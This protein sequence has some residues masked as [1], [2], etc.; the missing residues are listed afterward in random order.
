A[1]R[2]LA[3]STH[4]RID[5]YAEPVTSFLL[6]SSFAFDSSVAGLFWTLCTGGTLVMPG[7]DSHRDPSLLAQL[8]A[9]HHISHLLALPSF[10]SLLLE[11]A[12]EQ[13]LDSLRVAIVAGEACPVELVRRHDELLPE[14]RL[15]N[16]YG[17]TEAT[18]WSSV[19][20]CRSYQ[21]EGR[22]P[23][24]R[25]LANTQTYLLDSELQPVPVGVRGELYI[26]GTGLTHGY[27]RRAGITAERFIPNPFSNQKGARLYKTGDTA[28]Y[29]PGG[30]IDF[31]GRIDDQVKIRGYRIEPGEI[32]AA[33][34]EH[35][36]IEEGVV[37]VRQDED[38][39]K[40]LVGYVVCKP[41][42][43]VGLSEL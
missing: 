41:G 11:P 12:G 43:Q 9:S 28:R 6:L 32:E 34:N 4:A 20:N 31:L 10:Y 37:V 25:P 14:T 15:F 30:D 26:A 5:Y 38:E 36:A 19:Y 33:L 13:R 3:Q 17:P 27:I 40:R 35:A 1:H 23:I 39:D 7:E 29:L 16:E 18:V 22:V 21:K 42:Q 24:G 8:I 2:M